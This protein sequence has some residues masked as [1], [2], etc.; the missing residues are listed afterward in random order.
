MSNEIHCYADIYCKEEHINDVKKA[1]EESGICV[2]NG[3]VFTTKEYVEFAATYM[4]TDDAEHLVDVLGDKVDDFNFYFEDFDYGN[5]WRY[6]KEFGIESEETCY[7]SDV[8]CNLKK[9]GYSPAEIS[10][11]MDTIFLRKE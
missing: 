2:T 8:V 1:L 11:I 5:K 9:A 4:D 3:S 10:K 7:K 6:T